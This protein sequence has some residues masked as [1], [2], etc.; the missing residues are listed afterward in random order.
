MQ[1]RFA[2]SSDIVHDSSFAGQVKVRPSTRAPYSTLLLRAHVFGGGSAAVRQRLLNRAR[3]SDFEGT[4]T[5]TSNIRREQPLLIRCCQVGRIGTSGEG[6]QIWLPL[7]SELNNEADQPARGRVL[8]GPVSMNWPDT[9]GCLGWCLA[10]HISFL[11]NVY[12]RTVLPLRNP[13]TRSDTLKKE[14][15]VQDI[16]YDFGGRNGV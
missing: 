7:R 12:N 9:R 4:I 16:E 8:Q 11:I 14:T 2:Q 10:L 13:D 5:R 3:L 1:S 6:P 15:H